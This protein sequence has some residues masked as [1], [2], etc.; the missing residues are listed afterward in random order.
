MAVRIRLTRGGATVPV[1]NVVQ[2][3]NN[4]TVAVTYSAAPSISFVPG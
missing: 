1:G 3:A 2:M 4:D